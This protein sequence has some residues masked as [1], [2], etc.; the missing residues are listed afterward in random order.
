[1]P[2]TI[3]TAQPVTAGWVPTSRSSACHT[4]TML[5]TINV[6]PLTS[7]ASTSARRQPKVRAPRAGSPDAHAAAS[8]SA[9]ANP[10]ETLCTASEISARLPN[11]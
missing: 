4:I 8:A 3:T 7:A 2:P 10:S 9:I 11:R 6:T 1:M 5:S